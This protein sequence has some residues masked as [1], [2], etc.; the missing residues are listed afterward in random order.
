MEG[1]EVKEWEVRI[2]KSETI[3]DTK[4]DSEHKNQANAKHN[5]V[6]DHIPLLLLMK[7]FPFSLPLLSSISLSRMAGALDKCH[8]YHIP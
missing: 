4:Q 3:A 5:W 7:D 8:W 1:E 6:V 2:S